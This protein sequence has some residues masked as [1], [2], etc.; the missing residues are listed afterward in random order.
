[1]FHESV[2]AA[3]KVFSL[4]VARN[5]DMSFY[6]LFKYC[7]GLGKRTVG[8]LSSEQLVHYPL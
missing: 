2:G 8:D 7:L 4:L 5:N 6:P 1:M 3:C